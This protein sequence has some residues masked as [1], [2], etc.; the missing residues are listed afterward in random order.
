MV[1]DEGQRVAASLYDL[2][3]YNLLPSFKFYQAHPSINGEIVGRIVVGAVKVV[4]AGIK[5]IR[6]QSVVYE[7]GSDLPAD[8]TAH[9]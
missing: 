3:K 8:V 4:P 2:S 5:E 1:L 9:K 7:D 6:A